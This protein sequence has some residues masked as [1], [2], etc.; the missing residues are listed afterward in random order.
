MQIM[1][2]SKTN[3]S[4]RALKKGTNHQL[5]WSR[6]T[7]SKWNSRENNRRFTEESNYTSTT[8]TK[9]MARCY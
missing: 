3:C 6:S 1:E 8:C 5:L 7:S 2:D 9:K 4:P